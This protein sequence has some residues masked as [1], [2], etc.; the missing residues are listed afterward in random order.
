MMDKLRVLLVAERAERAR[1]LASTLEQAGCQVVAQRVGAVDL[2]ESLRAVAPD[3]VVVDMDSPDRD[4][5]EEMQRITREQPRPIV[6]FV[7]E[8]DNESI[9][10]AVRAGVAAYVVKGASA[11]RIRSVLEVARARFEHLQALESELARAQSMLADR[12]LIERAKGILMERRGLSEEIAF[13]ML[14]NMAMK[15]GVR[16]AEIARHVLAAAEII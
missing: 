1:D 7:D 3:I 8:T 4:T 2:H 6:M 9:R 14:R 13:Q 15:R 5:L 11:E 10:A 12:K 16:L